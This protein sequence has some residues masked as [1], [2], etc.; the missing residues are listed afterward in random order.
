MVDVDCTGLDAVTVVGLEVTTVVV[1]DVTV[2]AGLDVAVVLDVV[3]VAVDG[4]EDTAFVGWVTLAEACFEVGVEVAL[5]AEV[6]C[7]DVCFG[8]DCGFCVGAG[9]E[10]VTGAAIF[11]ATTPSPSTE[12]TAVSATSVLSEVAIIQ[13]IPVFT[14][15][16]FPFG[17]TLA[18]DS[19]VEDHNISSLWLL[20]VQFTVNL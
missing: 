5:G 3:G 18:T 9:C 14:A 2:V 12:T 10:L 13:A 11:S 6:A 8:V 19:S 20:G 16:T 7:W 17:D 15:S 4:L 1:L